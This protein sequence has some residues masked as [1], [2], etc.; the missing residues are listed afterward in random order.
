MKEVIMT[1]EGLKKLAEMIE[2]V[3]REIAAEKEKLKVKQ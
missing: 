1:S 3:K 2:K